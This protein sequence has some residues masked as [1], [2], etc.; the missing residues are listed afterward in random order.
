M[1]N[2]HYSQYIGDILT[3]DKIYN[4][5]LNLWREIIMN[6]TQQKL[7]PKQLV[8]EHAKLVAELSSEKNSQI[9]LSHRKRL[10]EIETE[11]KMSS[12]QIADQ[13]LSIYKSRY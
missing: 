9:L 7:V 3:I 10:S 4:I 2:S 11:L 12:E 5:V 6:T 13:A 1:V 8:L